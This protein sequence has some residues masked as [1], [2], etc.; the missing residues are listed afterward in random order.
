MRILLP[1]GRQ[2]QGN[3]SKPDTKDQKGKPLT[4]Q[5][6]SPRTNWFM[7]VAIP[8]GPE[9]EKI[10]QELLAEV[11]AALPT[12]PIDEIK[13][14]MHDGDTDPMYKGKEGAANCII[15][16]MSNGFAPQCY[17][18]DATQEIL[19]SDIKRGDYVKVEMSSVIKDGS[20]YLN[21][22]YIFKTRE[23][24]AINSGP[25]AAQVLAGVTDAPAPAAPAGVAA[26]PATPAAAAAPA[27]PAASTPPPPP[28]AAPAAALA[29]ALA[30]APAP[31]VM[32]GV[33]TEAKLLAEGWT[34]EQII[35]G[36][37]GKEA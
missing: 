12:T 14:K 37:H 17:N 9:I 15:V 16:R 11:R 25:T 19:P 33:H 35:A 13:H 7:G 28:A 4:N 5:D 18:A 30:A 22:G 29:A 36:G 2:I 8:K 1:E 3:L 21:F 6:G 27:T 32:T 23:G 26:T 24:T 34:R 31:L 10:Y 20:V